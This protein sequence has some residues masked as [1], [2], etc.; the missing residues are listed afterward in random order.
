MDDDGRRH[1]MTYNYLSYKLTKWAFGSDELVILEKECSHRAFKEVSGLLQKY[2]WHGCFQNS[3][4]A[5]KARKGPG[6]IW[7]IFGP[8]LE[9][10]QLLFFQD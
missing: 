1:T 4:Q 9:I 5:N 10:H 2:F 7:A 3:Y 8:H 6:M